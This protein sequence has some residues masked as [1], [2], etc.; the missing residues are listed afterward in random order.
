MRDYAFWSYSGSGADAYWDSFEEYFEHYISA[1]EQIAR[2]LPEGKEYEMSERFRLM[3]S[4]KISPSDEQKVQDITRKLSE[5]F[6]ETY[7]AKCYIREDVRLMLP[8]LAGKYRLGVVSNFMVAGG[9][10]ELLS[11]LGLISLFDF[12]ITSVKEGWKKP[13]PLIY[14]AALQKAGTSPDRVLF[15]GDDYTND[16]VGPG[17]MGFQTLYLDRQQKYP[18]LPDR[19]NDYHDLVRLL[20]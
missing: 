3:A 14:Q 6:W 10:E 19:I 7:K 16:Y 17:K 15:I 5:R 11:G 12:V 4:W 9:I 20:S 1:R 2:Q 8:R 13:H 18:G